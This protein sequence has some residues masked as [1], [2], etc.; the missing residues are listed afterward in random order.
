[1]IQRQSLSKTS[2]VRVCVKF[3]GCEY[4]TCLQVS[5]VIDVS[6]FWSLFKNSKDFDWKKVSALFVSNPKS[7]QSFS[8]GE[9]G[10]HCLRRS[11][12]HWCQKVRQLNA[13]QCHDY[14]HKFSLH[15]DGSPRRSGERQAKK[16]AQQTWNLT[17]IDNKNNFVWIKVMTCE[18]TKPKLTWA[19][20]TVLL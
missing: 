11:T 19:L 1:M 16:A 20:N 3:P 7:W 6:K 15:S 17:A 10:S 5:I 12:L 4:W 14:R 9:W 8:L 2:E 13:S 18:S